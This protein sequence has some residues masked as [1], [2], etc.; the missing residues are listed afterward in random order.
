MELLGPGTPIPILI[1]ALL[2][3]LAML[4]WG[5]DKLVDGASA[6]A[7]ALGVR[8][9]VI[10]LSCVAFGTS[11]PEL[12]TALFAIGRASADTVG[13]AQLALGNVIGSNVWNLGLI[14]GVA[15]VM[16]P[17][18][19]E[20]ETVR[21]E[22]PLLLLLSLL[23]AFCVEFHELGRGPGILLLAGF[24]VFCGLLAWSWRQPKTEGEAA[25]L[26]VDELRGMSQSKAIGLLVLGLVILVISAETLVRSAVTLASGLGVG[27]ELLG[28][29]VIALGTSLPELAT[30]V[31]AAR[32]GGQDLAFG[33]LIGSN[34]FNIAL[35]V[36]LPATLFTWPLGPDRMEADLLVMLGI[37]I[38][39]A[40]M[41]TWQ[42]RLSRLV[43]VLLLTTHF[44]YIG[45]LIVL[46]IRSP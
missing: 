14:L 6:L 44:V 43:G 15:A 27:E 1:V 28:L 9:F 13:P 40:V 11:A 3:S 8:P 16:Q 30:T 36:G 12:A 39:V 23:L 24:G 29:T 20:R 5:A 18:P 31:A 37:S 21:R 32:K 10:G 4:G 45:S 35:V 2:A 22:I 33:N 25:A 17:I 19:V 38:F 46:E 34:I 26:D 42:R 41:A 7:L